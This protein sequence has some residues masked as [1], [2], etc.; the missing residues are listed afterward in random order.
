MVWLNIEYFIYLSL[1]L[2]WGK[3][4]TNTM[5]QMCGRGIEQLRI[6]FISLI[7]LVKPHQLCSVAFPL[8]AK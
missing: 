4:D 5:Y 8:L 3:L 2:S 7:C 1:C 6:A